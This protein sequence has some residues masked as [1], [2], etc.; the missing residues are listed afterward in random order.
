MRWLLGDQPAESHGGLY[1]LSQRAFDGMLG[2]YANGLDVVLRHPRLT[3][4][5]MLATLAGTLWLY[6]VAP[7]GLFPQ[8]DTGLIIGVAKAAPDISFDAMADRIQRLGHIV[9]ADPDVDNVYYWIG[10]A[11]TLSQGRMLINLKP[12]TDRGCDRATRS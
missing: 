4:G 1:R 11:G 3:L 7:K 9:M 6:A 5:V 2:R 8:Q 10:E 12:F